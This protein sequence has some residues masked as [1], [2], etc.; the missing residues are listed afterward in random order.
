MTLNEKVVEILKRHPEGG[1][2]FFNALDL[3]VRGDKDILQDYVRWVQEYYGSECRRDIGVILTGSFGRVMVS[4]Y[5]HWLQDFFGDVIIVNGGIRS[6]N[7]VEL[8]VINVPLNDYILLDDSYYSGKTMKS[9][10]SA[11]KKLN[12][13][14][15]LSR[16]FVVYDGSKERSTKILGMYRYYNK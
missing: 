5:G 16:A 1:E 3:M 9:I 7:P 11:I 13:K 15:T 8:P 6:G 4:L 12:S 14:T 10:E 2:K